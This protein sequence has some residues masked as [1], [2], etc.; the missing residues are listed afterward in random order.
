MSNLLYT[1]L[2]ELVVI[3]KHGEWEILIH[4]RQ[5]AFYKTVL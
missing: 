3:E 5:A 4:Q 2:E 1:F